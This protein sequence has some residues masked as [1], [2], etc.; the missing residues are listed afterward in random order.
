MQDFRHSTQ[1]VEVNCALANHLDASYDSGSVAIW[2]MVIDD[3]YF[4]AST[5]NSEN[6]TWDHS[7][8]SAKESSANLTCA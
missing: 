1:D 5:S 8:G 7:C 2:G 6:D 3:E 4:S